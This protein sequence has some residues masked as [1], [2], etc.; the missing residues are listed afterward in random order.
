[1]REGRY[2]EAAAAQTQLDNLRQEEESHQ[3]Q[4]LQQKQAAELAENE[5]ILQRDYAAFMSGW[6]AKMD[7]LQQKSEEQESKLLHRHS[8]ELDQLQRKHDMQQQQ[9][10]PKFSGELLN[11]RKIELGLSKQCNFDKA[12]QVKAKAD[13]MEGAEFAKLQADFRTKLAQEEAK[14]LT[15]QDKERRALMTKVSAAKDEHAG[16]Q[17]SQL[18]VLLNKQQASK[19]LLERSHVQQTMQLKHA[20]R[21]M[22]GAKRGSPQ[23]ATNQSV[24]DV[25]VQMITSITCASPLERVLRV[26]PPSAAIAARLDLTAPAPT[27]AASVASSPLAAVRKLGSPTPSADGIPASRPSYSRAGLTTVGGRRSPPR[28]AARAHRPADILLV[29][30]S[31]LNEVAV[32]A[33]A[34]PTAAEEEVQQSGSSLREAGSSAS[35]HFPADS[36]AAAVA[37]IAAAD[38]PVVPERSVEAVA[39]QSSCATTAASTDQQ[40]VLQQQGASASALTKEPSAASRSS[41][42]TAEA[43]MLAAVAADAEHTSVGQAANKSERS[44]ALDS[45]GVPADGSGGGAASGMDSQRSAIA[46]EVSRTAA[47]GG[48]SGG[49][50]ETSSGCQPSEKEGGSSPTA[51]A[52]EEQPPPAAVEDEAKA[53][54]EAEPEG[55]AAQAVGS[56]AQAVTGQ[57]AAEQLPGSAAQAEEEQHAVAPQI[58]GSATQAGETH[59]AAEQP[60]QIDGAVQGDGGEIAGGGDEATESGHAARDDEGAQGDAVDEEPTADGDGGPAGDE[61]NSEAAHECA[62]D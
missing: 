22:L 41:A 31:S 2:Y 46:A 17:R 23:G 47:A 34:L 49:D 56:A 53:E 26:T 62:E 12:L 5:Y 14:L 61:A 27:V 43:P 54:R 59:N 11:L 42:A 25:E 36:S 48:R 16:L 55:S 37:S 1:M 8:L 15:Q 50:A 9:F 40:S 6:E 32:A 18:H 52:S 19:L 57:D 28:D 7:V 45:D 30:S 44:G 38:P 60:E 24:T 10:Q 3:M 35:V 58:E 20:L 51:A 4:T 13:E 39:S 33:T 21:S 29:H